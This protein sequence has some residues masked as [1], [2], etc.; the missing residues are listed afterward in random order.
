MAKTRLNIELIKKISE[1]VNYSEK[2][3]REQI[4]KRANK[5]GV[6]SEAYLI[7]WAKELGLGTSWYFRKLPA[8]IQQE[9]SKIVNSEGKS[10]V[11][12]NSSFPK[13]PK[14]LKNIAKER[15]YQKWW[16]LILIGTTIGVISTIIAVVI[17]NSAGL[18]HP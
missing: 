9:V 2:Y 6:N 16:G 1:K 3:I 18:T 8:H 12:I 7:I 17:T 5:M 14:E 13:W 15:W 4:S 10:A 11:Q